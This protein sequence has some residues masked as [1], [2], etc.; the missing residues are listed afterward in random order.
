MLLILTSSLYADW[1]EESGI[2]EPVK[3]F[4]R[5]YGT[6]QMSKV[7]QVVTDDFRKGKSKSDWTANVSRQLRDIQYERLDSEIKGQIVSEGMATILMMATIR[8][9][10]GKVEQDFHLF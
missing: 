9:V 5:Y 3:I 10:A 6:E 1:A 4:D 8:T 2:L 7:T